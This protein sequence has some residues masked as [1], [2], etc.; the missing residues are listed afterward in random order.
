MSNTIKIIKSIEIEEEFAD[1]FSDFLDKDLTAI[2]K[3]EIDCWQRSREKAGI[4]YGTIKRD[5]GALKTL[6]NRAVQDK[7]I[8]NN[9]LANYK[10]LEPTQKDQARSLSDP[11]K[12]ERRLLTDKEIAGILRGLEQFAEEIRKQRKNSRV[13]GKP[14]LPDLDSVNYPHW[15]I[16]FCHL[17]LHTGM[18]PGDLYS[19]T[20]EELNVNFGRLKKICEKT[21][22]ALRRDKKPTELDFQLN[23]TILDIMVKLHNDQG[24]PSAGLVLP[25]PRTGIQLDSQAHRKP[26]GHIKRLS[27][28]AP[29]LNF[30]ALRHHFISA[31][32]AA[33]VPIFTVAKL[34]GHKG[35]E[36]ISEHYGHLCPN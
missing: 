35:I 12:V 32:L 15:F 10:L 30:Y 5:C 7:I 9:P 23:T 27:G 17:A 1:W 24:K 36:M 13:H 33:G 8:P 2:S 16:P 14:E 6:L 25:S 4:K 21:A 22:H 29:T 18:R 28:I 3:M 20:W 31:M 11:I 34:A 26:W 19:L